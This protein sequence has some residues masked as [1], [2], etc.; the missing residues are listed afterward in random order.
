VVCA[1]QGSAIGG[2]LGVAM[3]ADFRVAAPEARFTANFARLGFHH[4]LSATLP[5]VIGQ[6]RTLELLC[7]GRRLNGDEALAIGLCDRLVP[8]AGLRDA[9][10]AF[11]RDIAGSAPLAVR[12]IRET[13]RRPVADAARAAM[14]R[15]KVEQD[16]L[17]R[18]DDVRE[19]VAATAARR[20]PDFQGR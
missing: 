8:L 5:P 20:T 18:T 16:R 1:V 19:G 12:S 9:A 10:V 2:G 17:H 4:A 7:T 11:A 13:M 3:S 14:A 6:Q 15:E